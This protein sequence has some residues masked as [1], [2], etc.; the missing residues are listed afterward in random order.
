M[1][2]PG[3]AGGRGLCTISIPQAVSAILIVLTGYGEI[4]P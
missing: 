3:S 1:G 4:D 2:R